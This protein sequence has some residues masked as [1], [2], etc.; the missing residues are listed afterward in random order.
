MVA[1]FAPTPSNRPIGFPNAFFAFAWRVD[2]SMQAMPTPT[3]STE[4]ASLISSSRACIRSQPA[5]TDPPRRA[6]SV[7]LQFSRR[8]PAVAA[9]RRPIVSNG[10]PIVI[11][12]ASRSIRKRVI[13]RSRPA[14]RSVQARTRKKSANGAFVTRS[15]S[16]FRI[17][18][19]SLPSAA[20]CIPARS[21]PA[22][23]SVQA[24]API[25][26]PAARSG[27]YRS[28]WVSVLKR[29]TVLPKAVAEETAAR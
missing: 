16:P 24:N 22:S 13:P 23:L 11:P 19:P 15:F 28:C 1:S 4:R 18:R 5:P 10:L 8:I 25:L 9:P 3:H 20:V 27:R 21:D 6:S 26:S 7:T 17:Q 2:S 14:S 12:I 29:F